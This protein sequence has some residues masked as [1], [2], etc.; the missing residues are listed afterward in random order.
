MPSQGMLSKN[1]VE[2]H[3]AE[4]LDLALGEQQTVERVAGGGD[5]VDLCQGMG[6]F[7]GKHSCSEILH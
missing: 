1:P 2:G 5:R 4:V 6:S 3:K 7:N